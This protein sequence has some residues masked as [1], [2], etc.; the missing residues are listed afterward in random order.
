MIGDS[1]AFID[2]DDNITI[3]GT[4]FR[5]TEGLW[6]LLTRK[7]VNMQL[8]GKEDLKTYKK[9]LILTNAHLTRYQPGDN[10]NITRGKKFRN[11]IAPLF[12]KP[13]GRGVESSLRRR[14]QKY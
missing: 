12:A 3:K 13:N 6:E 10:I 2:P 11:V 4:V 7:N 8:T 14:W 5:G 9:I 1:P